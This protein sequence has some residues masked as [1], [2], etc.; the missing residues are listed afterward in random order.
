MKLFFELNETKDGLVVAGGED[1]KGKVTIP[2]EHEYEGNMYPV[3]EIGSF[4]F[5]RCEGLE[6][7]EVPSSVT[8]IILPQ[9]DPVPFCACLFRTIY[10]TGLFPRTSSDPIP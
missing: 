2:S 5:D 9:N 4:A 3:K 7:I 6:S 8:K 1:T 10:N